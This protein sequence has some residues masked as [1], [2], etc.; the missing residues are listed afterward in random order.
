[1]LSLSCQG[2]MMS[3]VLQEKADIKE[4][5]LFD[6]DKE[7]LNILLK[8]R[9][10]NKNIIWAVDDYKIYGDTFAASDYITVDSIT[11]KNGEVIKP[12]IQKT[13]DEKVI[14][15]RG[16]AE[17]FTPAW[18][19]NA[20]NNLVDNDWFKSSDIF[21]TEIEKDWITNN[22]KI[23]FPNNRTWQEYVKST[24][25]EITCGEAPYLTSR[26]DAVTGEYIEPQNRIGLLDR[27]LRIISENIANDKEWIDWAKIA[28]KN[29]Y[30]FDWQGD[31]VLLARENI[32]YAIAEY[33]EYIYGKNLS[34][35]ILKELA[36]IISWNIWQMDGLK[37]VIPNS[38][39]EKPKNE[40]G[41]LNLFE[42]EQEK[43][44]AE[45]LPIEGIEKWEKQCPG[46]KNNDINTHTGIYC[47]IMDWNINRPV[48]FVSLLR[49]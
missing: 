13:A 31:N 12:R 18:L 33:Y 39:V 2:D 21:N 26:Y 35:D 27:K 32:L 8:D 16:K 42:F 40:S 30:G 41:Q 47:K 25:L 1:M 29:I 49:G 23:S 4:N 36:E 11:G 7:L 3:V 37:C 44:E 19:C 45:Q 9:T 17:V 5:I 6:L 15:I 10:S 22:K 46:C 24:R 14:R 20:Q 28:V 48:K 43:K 34:A 38:C